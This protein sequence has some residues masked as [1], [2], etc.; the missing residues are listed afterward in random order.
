MRQE[1]LRPHDVCVLLGLTLHPDATYRALAGVVG[2]SLGETHNASKRLELARLVAPGRERINRTGALDFLVFG[3]P[4]VFPAQMG[5][6]ARGIPTAHSAPPIAESVQPTGSPIVWPSARGPARGS[7]LVPLS[8]V[9]EHIWESDTRLYQL[10]AMVDALR[11]GR[12]RERTMAKEH[13]ER[14]LDGSV[15]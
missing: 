15:A 10:V 1:S 12:V 6:P 4:Y 14:F 13:L 7:S 8:D 5:G 3:V 9:V 11:V 2:L